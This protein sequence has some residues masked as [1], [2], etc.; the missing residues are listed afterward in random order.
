VARRRTAALFGLIAAAACAPSKDAPAGLGR[1]LAAGPVRAVLPSPDGAS[2]AVLDGCREARSSVLP[3]QT[4]SCDLRV[5]AAD[6]GGGRKVAV[7]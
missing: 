7:A 1:P 4:A 2:L 6:G 3:P 5:L